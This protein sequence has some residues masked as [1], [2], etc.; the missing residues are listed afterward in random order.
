VYVDQLARCDR[1]VRLEHHVVEHGNDGEP[2]LAAAGAG[3][4]DGVVV[5]D[6]LAA[7]R[8]LDGARRIGRSPVHLL[9]GELAAVP[10]SGDRLDVEGAEE[11][12]SGGAAGALGGDGDGLVV[13]EE[14]VLVLGVPL[15]S[16][17]LAGRDDAALVRDGSIFVETVLADEASIGG[18]AVDELHVVDVHADVT[19]TG[20]V[21]VGLAVPGIRCHHLWRTWAI[22]SGVEEVLEV[23]G[24]AVADVGPQ[25]QRTGPLVGTEH[26]VAGRQFPAVLG[27]HIA[28]QRI[29]EAVGV[30]RPEA[31]VDDDLVEGDDVGVDL[32]VAHVRLGFRRRGRV[33]EGT[34]GRQ[35][36]QRGRHCGAGDD[37][38]P[39]AP[40]RE[41]HP[42]VSG[43]GGPC[44]SALSGDS[45]RKRGKS[46]Q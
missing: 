3:R 27:H 4:V 21:P 22:L 38:H 12:E 11:A 43:T 16:G 40:P 20:P 36:S 45:C 7:R 46:Q 42:G 32:A 30:D 15:V 19:V 5:D 29:H 34:G 23:D 41:G 37:G 14:S 44:D 26:D 1:S 6:R 8:Q 25:H 2:V 10:H 28:P 17:R 35:S 33:G 18:D 39:G 24:D 9:A 13:E 31:V